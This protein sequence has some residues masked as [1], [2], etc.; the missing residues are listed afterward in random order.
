V[1]LLVRIRGRNPD[2]DRTPDDVGPVIRDG[3][4]ITGQNPESSP[5]IALALIDALKVAA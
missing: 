4:L 3:L 1:A 5:A 2:P